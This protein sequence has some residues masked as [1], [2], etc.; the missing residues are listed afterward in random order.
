MGTSYTYQQ[1]KSKKVINKFMVPVEDKSAKYL[2]RQEVFD[3]HSD[4]KTSK[5]K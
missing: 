3:L 4:D 5:T 1:K 2:Q